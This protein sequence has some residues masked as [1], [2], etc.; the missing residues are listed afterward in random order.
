MDAFVKSYGKKIAELVQELY[1]IEKLRDQCTRK[2]TIKTIKKE[3]IKENEKILKTLSKSKDSDRVDQLKAQ[4]DKYLLDIKS[5]DEFLDQTTPNMIKIREK[6]LESVLNKKWFMTTESLSRQYLAK[7]KL[8]LAQEQEMHA[9]RDDAL[10]T[11]CEKKIS[12]EFSC[13]PEQHHINEMNRRRERQIR[14]E[15]NVKNESPPKEKETEEFKLN[16]DPRNDRILTNLIMIDNYIPELSNKEK[17]DQMRRSFFQKF[18]HN[19]G[20]KPITMKSWSK[21]AA[22]K[23]PETDSFEFSQL[24]DELD[25]PCSAQL[26]RIVES[27][28]RSGLNKSSSFHANISNNDGTWM[29][30]FNQECNRENELWRQ[31]NP[32][33]PGTSRPVSSIKITKI[34]QPES[35]IVDDTD[36]SSLEEL[37]PANLERDLLGSQDDINYFKSCLQNDLT[38][39]NKMK[40][41]DSIYEIKKPK[42]S[43][44]ELIISDTDDEDNDVKNSKGLTK[45]QLNNTVLDKRQQNMENI[46]ESKEALLMKAKE[47]LGQRA[48]YRQ[49]LNKVQQDNLKS[50]NHHQTPS[51]Q[52]GLP[53]FFFIEKSRF[54]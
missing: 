7:Y 18:T 27:N 30:K 17:N 11:E 10:I 46:N 44:Q 51:E 33:Q 13:N 19:D 4:I 49:N 21:S 29:E 12:S 36:G 23:I 26:P 3:Q 1:A 43:K 40:P 52:L 48:G 9:I 42:K 45:K 50:S 47:W 37:Y 22:C 41:S 35:I 38:K 25:Y 16:D 31:N 34:N 15:K 5:I 6:E 2:C 14:D 24:K 28:S 54:L 8:A 39:Q 32:V 53:R 20:D